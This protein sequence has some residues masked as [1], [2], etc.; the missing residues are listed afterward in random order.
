MKLKLLLP[1]VLVVGL[2]AALGWLYTADAKKDTELSALRADSAEL[3]Q[4]RA[5]AEEAKKADTQAQNDELERLRK[6]H[7]ELL[8][9][10]NEARQLRAERQQ[11]SGQVQTAQ[12]QAANAQAQAQSAKTAQAVEQ[13]VAEARAKAAGAPAPPNP[14]QAALN[15]CINNLRMIDG[16]KAQWALEAQKPNGAIMAPANLL[17]YLPN[18]TMPTCPAGGIYTLNPVGQPPI[19]N[20][21]GH[22]LAR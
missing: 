4:L 17:P 13:A 14:E 11:L 5:Q 15:T 20:V 16:A 21:P 18:N 3:Q 2:G 7:E 1:W 6:D 19:C 8:R 10:R 9:L 22:T 12:A